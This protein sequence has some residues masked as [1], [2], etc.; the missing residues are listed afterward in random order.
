[1]EPTICNWCK[2]SPDMGMVVST[3]DGSADLTY[4]SC[5]DCLLKAFIKVLGEPTIPPLRQVIK[6]KKLKAVPRKDTH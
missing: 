4:L 3:T 6:P 5:A 1:M 2:V